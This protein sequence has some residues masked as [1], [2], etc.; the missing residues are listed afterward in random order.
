M[1]GNIIFCSLGGGRGHFETFLL[2]EVVGIAILQEFDVNSRFFA[3][4]C[5][6]YTGHNL[7]FFYIHVLLEKDIKYGFE[8]NS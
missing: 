6:P 5:D 1:F 2:T 3:T 4:S 7:R 8:K